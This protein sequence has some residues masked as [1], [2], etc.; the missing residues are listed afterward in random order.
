M[1]SL[2]GRE[3]AEQ[4]DDRLWAEAELGA[5]A[6]EVGGVD[7]CE[8]GRINAVGDR[9]DSLSCRRPRR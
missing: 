7:R 6:G 3:P 5:Q 8:R 2:P 9:D 4:A 1:L